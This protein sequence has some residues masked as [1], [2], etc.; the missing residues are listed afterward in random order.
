MVVL[1]QRRKR[2]NG[3][4]VL[5]RSPAQIRP[6]RGRMEADLAEAVKVELYSRQLPKPREACW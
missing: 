3:T 4:S 5:D 2:V 6:V 1:Q